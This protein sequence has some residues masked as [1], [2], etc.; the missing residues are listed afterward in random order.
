[1][2]M[3]VIEE[4]FIAD[5]EGPPKRRMYLFRDPAPTASHQTRGW[6]FV[7][8]DILDD[9]GVTPVWDTW[10]ELFAEIARYPAEYA[11]GACV[12]RRQNGGEQVTLDDLSRQFA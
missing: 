4:V 9:G 5:T 7:V 1:M 3:D 10:E 12:W 8:E 6:C 2:A 11:T